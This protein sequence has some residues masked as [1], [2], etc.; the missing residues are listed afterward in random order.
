LSRCIEI[1]ETGPLSTIQ[2]LGRPGHSSSGVPE[3]GALDSESLRAA[4]RL[5]GNDE[6]C[7]GIEVTYGGLCLRAHGGAV[8]AVTGAVGE[9]RN[10]V[11]SLRSHSAI[12]VPDGGSIWLGM[13]NAGVRCYLAVRGGVEGSRVYGSLSTDLLSGLGSPLDSGQRLPVGREPSQPVPPVD[14]LPFSIRDPDEEVRVRVVLGPRNHWFT[15][16]AVSR[17][18]TGNWK[19]DARS[20]RV[21]LRLAGPDLSRSV[22]GELLSEGVIKGAVQVPSGGQPI[23]FLND[24]PVTGGYPV[25]AVVLEEDLNLLA[26][27]R[28]G[29]SIRFVRVNPPA[30]LNVHQDANLL[31]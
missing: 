29:Q 11:R 20:N 2:D 22:D 14:V 8:V 5:V 9:I 3:S 13:P 18:V 26:Q 1:L 4:N 19:V 6:A 16:E 31:S 28:A 27:C 30:L 24:H 23:V 21:G 25:I 7:A 12:Y 17:L 10:D 15:P